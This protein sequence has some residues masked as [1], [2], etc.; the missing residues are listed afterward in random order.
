MRPVVGVTGDLNT[1]MNP[2]GNAGLFHRLEQ[3]GCEVWPSPFFANSA[4]ASSLETRK[5][6]RQMRLLGAMKEEVA[7]VLT[8]GAERRLV[9][10]LPP[11]VA[12]VATEPPAEELIRLAQPYLGPESHFL[13][14]LAVGKIADF[15][16]RGAAGVISAA[17]INC[18][19][20][21][22]ACSMIPALRADFA[23]AP[24]LSMAYG[25]TEGPSQRIRLETF[26]HQVHERWRRRAA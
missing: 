5:H 20:G 8:T 25:G 14:V 1:R 15:L 22:V 21:T 3:L 4:L 7:N 18:M 9:G 24:V 19:V 6:V 13:I 11:E 26:V 10:C 17:G 16:H 2:L 12:A 23:D